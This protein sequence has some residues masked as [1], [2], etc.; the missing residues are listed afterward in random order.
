MA[1]TE[2][3]PPLEPTTGDV[4][5]AP[6]RPLGVFTR[7]APS[8]SRRSSKVAAASING[9]TSARVDRSGSAR[10]TRR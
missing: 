10:S 7:R 3:R 8:A 6:T 1:I 5:P 4:E 2:E 9:S